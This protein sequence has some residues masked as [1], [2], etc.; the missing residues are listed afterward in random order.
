MK[1]VQLQVKA[2]TKVSGKVFTGPRQCDG[3]SF[4]I[5]RSKPPHTR[6][7][8]TQAAEPAKYRSPTVRLMMQAPS[9]I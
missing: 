2:D 3:G 9:N 8:G 6:P 7:S 1:G 5:S 4:L